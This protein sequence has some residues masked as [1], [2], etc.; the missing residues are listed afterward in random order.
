MDLVLNQRMEVMMSSKSNVPV[1]A[2]FFDCDGTLIDTIPLV[3]ACK[4]HA[5][6]MMGREV[7][8]RDELIESIGIPIFEDIAN[9]FEGEDQNKYFKYYQEF[10]AKH[11]SQHLAVFTEAYRAVVELWKMGIPLGV[12]T[13]RRRGSTLEL[14]NMFHMKQYFTVM[15][16]AG[17][18]EISKP[19]ADPL[20]EAV[21]RLNETG[22]LVGEI[23]P[24]ETVYIGDAHHDVGTANA[25]N[26][27]AV[28]VEWT[29]MPER[30]LADLD[31]EVKL[32][33]HRQ[34]IEDLG[35]S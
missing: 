25:A 7:P 10:Q 21:R 34:L 9:Y 30:V 19:H 16:N 1:K 14:L 11:L 3:V 35:L 5:F 15:V 33:N 8:P 20:L 26:A 6:T 12:V 18:T 2:V 22:M 24:E 32:K 29:N 23:R 31:Y 4:E 27:R 17:D 13:S 28:L